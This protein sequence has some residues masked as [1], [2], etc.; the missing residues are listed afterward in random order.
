MFQNLYFLPADAID[1]YVPISYCVYKTF[2]FK[3][4]GVNK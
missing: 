2:Y 1:N 3:T 4:D